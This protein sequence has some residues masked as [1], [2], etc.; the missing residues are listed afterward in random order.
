MKHHRF[1]DGLRAVAILPV[2]LFHFNLAKVTGGYV[3]VDVFFVISGFLITGLIF[4]QL[5]EKHFS[6]VHFYERRARRIL[7]ALF[8]TCLLSTIAAFFLYMPH[9]FEQFS[10]SLEGIAGF[11]SN[12]IFARWTGYFAEPESTKPLLHT[13]S[14]A[15]EEQF[16]VL[17]PLILYGLH[18]YF[19]DRT[20]AIRLGIYA[21]FAI[22]FVLNLALLASSPEKTFF[23]LHTRAWELLLGAIL[24]LNIKEV[25][26]TRLEAEAMSGAGVVIL[27][28]CFFIYDRNMPFPG[29]AAFPP[30]LATVFLLWANMDHETVIKKILASR[31]CVCIG[32]ISYGLYLYHW[33][34]IVF[35]RYYYDHEP[36]LIQTILML[37]ATVILAALSYFFVEKP[38]RTG[39]V[40]T[41][42]SL[43]IFSAAGLI[44]FG[45]IGM[46]GSTTKGLPQRFD[47]N[48]LQYATA[49]NDTNQDPQKCPVEDPR[50]LD[51]KT[52]CKIGA[53]AATPD[54]L[55]WG[56]SHASALQ[57]AFAS[58]ARE[59]NA[60]GWVVTY[61]GCPSLIGAERADNFVEF[62]CPAI[63]QTVLDMIRR[64]HI[65]NII[66][67]TRWDMYAL[68]WE[69]GGI[70]TAREPL[71]SFTTNDGRHLIREQAFAAAFQDTIAQLKTL[72]VRIWVVK[73]VPPQLVHV[74]SA[75]AKAAYFDRDP[76]K[77]ERSYDAILGRRR[78]I[79]KTF[80]VTTGVSFI[81]PAKA[82]CPQQINCL[83]VA[84]GKPLYS[85]D[86]H[87]SYD[88]ALWSKGM[89]GPFFKKIK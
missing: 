7:P 40:F 74:P 29:F 50:H 81:D 43:F 13:W 54:F 8:V 67:V 63:A 19:K 51:E 65:K 45:L 36:S 85:D 52:V 16:Y 56:D 61:S 58:L 4:S 17:F 89:L 32:L 22:S 62:S 6:I 70:E 55:L 71:L 69:K 30:C 88:G 41:R 82:F 20:H 57:P 39:K 37:K 10:K 80:I 42:K 35:T 31:L 3:G 83:I 77:L 1:I 46:I 60:S 9:D 21:I 48:V 53:S 38:V 18:R 5:Q 68:G 87:L 49:A 79:D 15:V 76:E 26:L 47:N 78:L 66:L 84:D 73:Q 64:N 27:L 28:L 72:G 11:V 12:F 25:S 14:L 33:P 34:V 44:V 24:A 23:L 2:I 75:L 86:T 59:H